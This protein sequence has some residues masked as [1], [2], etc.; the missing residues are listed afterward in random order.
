MDVQGIH[1]NRENS[2]LQWE[3]LFGGDDFNV[4]WAI[5][6]SGHYGANT[7]EAV[8]KIAAEE[9]DCF[10]HSFCVIVCIATST[11]V[12]KRSCLNQFQ[13]EDILKFV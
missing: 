7:T 6:C 1:Q 13:K 8:E 3:F 2:Y 4:V 11:A 5:F 10:K 12:E 9:K